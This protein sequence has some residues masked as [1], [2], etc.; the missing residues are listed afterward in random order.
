MP[1]PEKIRYHELCQLLL[2]RRRTEIGSDD[3]IPFSF[4]DFVNLAPDHN[5]E[6]LDNARLEEINN[7]LKKLASSTDENNQKFLFIE[8]PELL[9]NFVANMRAGESIIL[10]YKSER[11]ASHKSY[12]QKLDD[13]SDATAT[14]NNLVFDPVNHT[15]SYNGKRMRVLE[16]SRSVPV[17]LNLCLLLFNHSVCDIDNENPG[18]ANIR[19]EYSD[20]ELGA[21]VHYDAL[22]ELIYIRRGEEGPQND[23]FR[24]IRDAINDLNKRAENELGIKIFEQQNQIIRVV[25]P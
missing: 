2:E 24:P 16:Q 21:D 18:E 5:P 20:Y 13:Q 9:N 25:L 4:N 11:L 17:R 23:K 7:H 12:L 15:F 10:K 8:N 3:P 1:T 22:Y 19:N 6:Q 14:E